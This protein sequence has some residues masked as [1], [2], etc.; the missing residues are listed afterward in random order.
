MLL[1]LCPRSACDWK[2]LSIILKDAWVF[3]YMC[4]P[5]LGYLWL[6]VIH[7]RNSTETDG[8]HSWCSFWKWPF[9]GTRMFQVRL[10]PNEMSNMWRKMWPFGTARNLQSG[11]RSCACPGAETLADWTGR[12]SKSKSLDLTWSNAL[13]KKIN[14]PQKLWFCRDTITYLRDHPNGGKLLG[15]SPTVTLQVKAGMIQ[16]RRGEGNFVHCVCVCG[17]LCVCVLCMYIN[18]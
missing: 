9:W 6:F 14:I 3:F 2:S 18:M 16:T 7:P 13:P 11:P 12:G 10:Q 1:L 15:R 5:F 8:L 17:T 4:A